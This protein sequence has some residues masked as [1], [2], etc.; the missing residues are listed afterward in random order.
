MCY[1][2]KY[3]LNEEGECCYSYPPETRILMNNEF[4]LRYTLTVNSLASRSVRLRSA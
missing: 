4:A 1:K 2:E 3:E